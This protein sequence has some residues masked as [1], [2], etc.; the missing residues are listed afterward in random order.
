M[1]ISCRAAVTNRAD[2]RRLAVLSQKD[3]GAKCLDF[4]ARMRKYLVFAPGSGGE[5]MEPYWLMKWSD[6]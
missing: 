5:A 6:R 2:G 3:L 4:D 1:L